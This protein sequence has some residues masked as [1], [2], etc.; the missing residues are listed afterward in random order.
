MRALFVCLLVHV[1][2]AVF[3]QVHV[4][5]TFDLNAAGVQQAHKQQESGST[6]G[7][8]VLRLK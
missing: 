8:I 2:T 4:S 1:L 5:H 7:K 3:L 6:I